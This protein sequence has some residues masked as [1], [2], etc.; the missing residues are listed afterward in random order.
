MH[1][2]AFRIR[3]GKTPSLSVPYPSHS[4]N[5][6]SPSIY[7][8]LPRLS[9]HPSQKAEQEMSRQ[10]TEQNQLRNLNTGLGTGLGSMVKCHPTKPNEIM[11]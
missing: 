11:S 5:V 3:G 4:A 1:Y 10:R 2:D 8:L 7:Y 9:Q 6:L